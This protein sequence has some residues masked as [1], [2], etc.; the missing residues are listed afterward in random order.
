MTNENHYRIIPPSAPLKINKEKSEIECYEFV[1]DRLLVDPVETTG[2]FAVLKAFSNE[3]QATS[4][5]SALRDWHIISIIQDTHDPTWKKRLFMLD[6]GNE[7]LKNP[8]ACIYSPK[9][10]KKMKLMQNE[11]DRQYE[12]TLKNIKSSVK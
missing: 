7:L 10:V 2:L 5:I 6:F 8:Q 3:A 9:I 1:I 4:T 11:Y 12:Q